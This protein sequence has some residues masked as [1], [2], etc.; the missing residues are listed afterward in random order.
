MKKELTWFQQSFE[1][2]TVTYNVKHTD[3]KGRVYGFD[4]V[5]THDQLQAVA[6]SRGKSTWD[7]HDV[8]AHHYMEQ[9]ESVSL[10]EPP[11]NPDREPEPAP[12][13]AAEPAP[14]VE[15]GVD[16]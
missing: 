7:E 13:D 6:E 5:A 8:I 14:A 1:N 12:I 11:K 2:C 10:A 9:A 16:R 15:I 4:Y 3:D